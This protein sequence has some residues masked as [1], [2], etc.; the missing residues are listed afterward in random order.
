MASQNAP[1]TLVTRREPMLIN[2][3]DAYSTQHFSL[4]QHYEG[5]IESILIPAGLIKDRIE[6]VA[7]DIRSDYY[8]K[9]VHLMCVLKGGAAYFN[10]LLEALRNIHDYGRGE[11]I[12]V[13]YDFITCKS[14]E[15]TSSTGS[16]AVTGGNL[17]GLKG[18][19]VLLVEDIIDTG[20]TMAKVVPLLE[21]HGASSVRVTNLL[22]K[23]R[24]DGECHYTGDYVGFSIPDKFVVGYCLDYQEVYRDM[25]HIAIINAEGIE[26]VI[27]LNTAA[28][29]CALCLLL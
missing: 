24:D 23:R 25:M 4:P 1:A 6:R 10:D 20:A 19:H 27:S 5:T 13:T 2:V 7:R 17:E 15:G 16:V 9:T 26:K 11:Y 14:Y 28:A 8:G 21:S 22:E 29:S 12:P 3:E 18:K